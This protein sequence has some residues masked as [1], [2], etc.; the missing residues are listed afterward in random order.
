MV[1]GTA[2]TEA[3]SGWYRL[4]ALGIATLFVLCGV[5]AIAAVYERT[6]GSDFVAFWAAGRLALEGNAQAAYDIARHHAVE[7]Q[8]EP[9]AGILPF[10]YPPF[11]LALSL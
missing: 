2:S 10:P 7:L 9:M 5:A 8:A 11:A 6:V 3:K 1:G 4:A